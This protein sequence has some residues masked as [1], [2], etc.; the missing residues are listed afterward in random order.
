MRLPSCKFATILPMVARTVS[1]SASLYL[2]AFS[3]SLTMIPGI[4]S[5]TM[6]LVSWSTR[7]TVGVFMPSLR[8]FIIPLTSCREESPNTTHETETEERTKSVSTSPHQARAQGT[9]KPLRTLLVAGAYHSQSLSRELL[10]QDGVPVHLV[11]PLLQDGLLLPVLGL[12][13]PLKETKNGEA[14]QRGQQ[15]TQS[16]G[17]GAGRSLHGSPRT[18]LPRVAADGLHHGTTECRSGCR[19]RPREKDGERER[20]REKYLFARWIR[21]SPPR[22]PGT[23]A[24]ISA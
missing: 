12:E 20:E 16:R 18:P 7:R 19:K 14:S 8:A 1:R 3:Q 23:G 11:K 6:L 21:H 2:P 5:I 10:V 24:C 4:F 13:H 22:R 17:R 15:P 9:R